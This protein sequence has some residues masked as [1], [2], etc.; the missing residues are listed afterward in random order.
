MQGLFCPMGLVARVLVLVALTLVIMSAQAGAQAV[1]PGV[2]GTVGLT[3]DSRGNLYA[4]NAD[5]GEIY[6]IPPTASPVF[7]ARVPDIPTSLAV[8]R[9]RTIFVGTES[10]A[11]YS[12]TLAG[13]VT[14]VCRVKT[15][16]AGVVVDRDGNLMVSTEDGDIVR[17]AW[18]DFGRLQVP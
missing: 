7:L 18:R 5:T 13:V 14:E 11:V 10:G 9:L 4:A 6:C 15:P 17:V 8:G 1:L 3:Q 12:V 2:P 16:V